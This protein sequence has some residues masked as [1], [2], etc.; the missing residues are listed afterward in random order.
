MGRR[1]PTRTQ[2]VL[3]K[4][5]R[6]PPRPAAWP[7]PMRSARADPAQQQVA[8]WPPTDSLPGSGSPLVG[9]SAGCC[10]AGSGFVGKQSAHRMGEDG[11]GERDLVFGGAH[12][13][14]RALDP[15]SISAESF[16]RTG[17]AGVANE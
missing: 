15:Q 11:S 7:A 6:L 9:A 17:I 14:L 13:G 8:A 4:R 10:L 16:R 12:D 2:A 1:S 5:R 3:A